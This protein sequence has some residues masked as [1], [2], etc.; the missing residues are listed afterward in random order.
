MKKNLAKLD[1]KT[2]KEMGKDFSLYGNKEELIR[3]LSEYFRSYNITWK[4]VVARYNFQK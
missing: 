4:D 3:K 1:E 2:L